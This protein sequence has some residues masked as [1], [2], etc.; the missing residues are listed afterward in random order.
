MASFDIMERVAS[1]GHAGRG[2]AFM[3]RSQHNAWLH[4]LATVVAVATG[5]ALGLS[6]ADWKW[7]VATIT[8]VWVAETV[9]T[10]FEHLCNVVSPEYNI[11][12]KRAK[13][14]A[15]GAVLICAIG[16]VVMGL[17]IFT[18]YLMALSQ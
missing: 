11:S 15:A 6:S 5:F 1:F 16:A 7:L 10:A 18:P 17:L 12:V 4:A 13:D 9:N 3:L 2:L 8:T 14:V